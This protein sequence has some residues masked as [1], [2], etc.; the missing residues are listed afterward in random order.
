MSKHIIVVE[1][2]WWEGLRL[3]SALL[4]I[5]NVLRFHILCII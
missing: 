4:N 3:K 1:Q 5:N 2:T